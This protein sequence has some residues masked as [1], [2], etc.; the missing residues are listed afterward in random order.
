M[1]TLICAVVVSFVATAAAANPAHNKISSMSDHDR[2]VVFAKLLTNSGDRC[3]SA[4]KT[5]FQG[6]DKA[7]N[8]YW[9]VQCAGAKAYQIQIKN[10]STGS[11]KILDCAVMKA[12]N[13][14]AC[15]K[16]L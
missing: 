11:T 14:G 15:F 8:A 9:S 5:F 6:S 3:Q 13:L 1:K 7:G 12:A 16:K 2:Q 4:S 10:N